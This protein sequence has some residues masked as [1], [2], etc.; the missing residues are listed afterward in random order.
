MLKTIKPARRCGVLQKFCTEIP[1]VF[2][3]ATIA[4]QKYSK[5][6]VG[7]REKIFFAFFG[8]EAESTCD[9]SGGVAGDYLRTPHSGVSFI[10]W[11]VEI[12][13]AALSSIA[14]T[15]IAHLWLWFIVG[16]LSGVLA[17]TLPVFL[18]CLI[19]SLEAHNLVPTL[20]DLLFLKSQYSTGLFVT[21]PVFAFVSLLAGV[22]A[23]FVAAERKQ[24]FWL[25][26]RLNT[27]LLT[28]PIVIVCT[29]RLIWKAM[30]ITP[31]FFK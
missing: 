26:I 30:S 14:S 17:M 20:I 3:S 28:S 5:R 16:L 11:I 29:S 27:A 4:R 21:V 6:L 12:K 15:F 2:L 8:R 9:D 25:C 22:V 18:D 1:F 24:Q 19:G 10:S 23:Q 13:F 31:A 7:R